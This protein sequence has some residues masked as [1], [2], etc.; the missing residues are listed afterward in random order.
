MCTSTQL[1]IAARGRGK[2]NEAERLE[3]DIAGMERDVEETDDDKEEKG[4]SEIRGQNIG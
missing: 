3:A 4:Q 2:Q 1:L